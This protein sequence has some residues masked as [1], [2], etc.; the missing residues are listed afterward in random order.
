MEFQQSQN[1]NKE[2]LVG[3]SESDRLRPEFLLPFTAVQHDAVSEGSCPGCVGTYENQAP[4][5]MQ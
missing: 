4:R 1:F 5:K 3:D 2:D